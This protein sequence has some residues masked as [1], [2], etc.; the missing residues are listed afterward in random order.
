[1]KLD[2]TIAWSHLKNVILATY[3]VR[4]IHKGKILVEKTLVKERWESNWRPLD[5]Q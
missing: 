2:V 3:A 5:L 1:M 4:A